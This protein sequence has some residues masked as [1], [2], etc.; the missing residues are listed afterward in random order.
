MYQNKMSVSRAKTSLQSATFN[1]IFLMITNLQRIFV[2][3][4]TQKLAIDCERA[5]MTFVKC[6]NNEGLTWNCDQV[7]DDTNLWRVKRAQQVPTQR[8][9][10]ARSIC[11]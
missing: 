11:N 10:E 6:H 8:M 9:D 2:L 3:H 7:W 1:K 5:D 4:E